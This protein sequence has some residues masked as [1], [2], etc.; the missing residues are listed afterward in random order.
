MENI[1]Y[2]GKIITINPIEGADFIVS[3]TVV[4]G[5]GGKWMG[6]VKKDQFKVDDLVEVYLQAELLPET[7]EVEFM[8]K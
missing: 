3:A 1:A 8:K 6:T 5:K 7:P 2:V 4:C